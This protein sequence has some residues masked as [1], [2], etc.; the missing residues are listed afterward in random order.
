MAAINVQF[1]D[2]MGQKIVAYF[3]SPQDPSAY[4]NL[5]TVD[6]SD[7]R[8]ASFYAILGGA[9]SGLP[10]PDVPVSSAEV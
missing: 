3:S 2:S 4:H 5:G 6:T 9:E 7:E 10:T 1:S 8:W